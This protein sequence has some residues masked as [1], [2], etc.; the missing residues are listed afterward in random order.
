MFEG[1]GEQ[2]APIPFVCFVMV[3]SLI[4]PGKPGAKRGQLKRKADDDD[5]DDDDDDEKE[6]AE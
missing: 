5:D 1:Q 6:D 4:V 2:E 3:P